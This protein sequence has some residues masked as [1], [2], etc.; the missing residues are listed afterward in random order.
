MTDWPADALATAR[1]GKI[2]AP[3]V[4]NLVVVDCGI[5]RVPGVH[6]LPS[7][8]VPE[9]TI[10]LVE[11]GP[12]LIAGGVEHFGQIRSRT[13]TLEVP[14]IEQRKWCGIVGVHLV[15]EREDQLDRM[16]VEA[17]GGSLEHFPAVVCFA[18]VV[19]ERLVA[20]HPGKSEAIVCRSR[21][22]G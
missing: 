10:A 2:A 11:Q 19:G 13:D 6:P 9:V 20:A 7:I 15:A 18:A 21:V 12:H 1:R 16:V 8:H 4:D 14:L 3:V 22:G 17:S 5:A